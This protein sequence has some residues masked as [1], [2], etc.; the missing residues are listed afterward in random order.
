MLLKEPI[1]H[2]VAPTA[3]NDPD[4][5]I[6]SVNVEKHSSR[7]WFLDLLNLLPPYPTGG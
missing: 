4:T 5:N 1:I 3:E 2:K 7:A 6:K